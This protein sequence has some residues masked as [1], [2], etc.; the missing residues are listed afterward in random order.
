MI[1]IKDKSDC[2]GCNAC[3]DICSKKCIHFES[4][5]EGFLYPVVDESKCCNCHLCESICPILHHS[6]LKKIDFE[7]PDCYAAENKNIEVIFDSTTGGLFSAFANECYKNHGFVGGAVFS[8]DFRTVKQIITNNRSD[9]KT[10]RKSKYLQSNSEGFYNSVKD[11]LELSAPVVVCGL[12]CQM[13]AL[14]SFLRK[15]YENLLIIDLI[16]LGVNSPLV[17]NKYIDYL[18]K[19][20]NSKLKSI[21]FKSKVAYD[22]PGAED[23]LEDALIDDVDDELMTT[24]SEEDD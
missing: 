21:Q 17:W 10:L 8:K 4:D 24:E 13:A 20:Q 22:E 2:C 7:Q 9:L 5:N 11:A 14:R 6:E 1:N 19:L 3:G 18:E 16:C 12:P 23:N 15:D